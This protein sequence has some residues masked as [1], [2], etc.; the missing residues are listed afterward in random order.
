[1]SYVAKYGFIAILASQ[2][3]AFCGLVEAADKAASGASQKRPNVLFLFADDQRP[4][5]IAALGNPVIKTPN[6]DR[7]VER[8]MTFTNAYCMGST[9]PAVC[10]PSRHMT[11]SGMSL[12][13]YDPKKMEGTFGDVMRKAGY[14][15]YHQSKSGNTA[16]N[17]HKA[18]E[19]SSYLKDGQVRT[20]G[21][22]GRQAADDAISFLEGKWDRQQP[23][24]MYI[25]FAGPHDPRVAAPEWMDLYEREKIPLPANYAPFHSIDNAELFIRDEKL[26][27]WPR[28][29]DEVR[30]HLHDYYGCISSID[31]NIGRILKALSDLGQ[32]DNTIVVFSADHGLAIGSHGLFGKQNLYE[33]SMGT[34]LVFAGP[35]V[36]HGQTD[37]YAYLFDIF[38]TVCDLTGVEL[39][40]GLDGRSQGPV[41]RN[42]KN[43]VRDRVFLAYR[44]GQ[45]AVRVGDWKLIRYPQVNATQLFNLR[46]DPQELNNL[47]NSAKHAKRV[48]ELMKQLATAQQEFDDTL[49]LSSEKPGQAEVTLEY[50]RTR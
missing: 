32:L 47:A 45:R 37:A 2:A 19:Y 48:E 43:S 5:T 14:V 46:D 35:G 15:T 10:N 42:E 21:H 17:Y 39:P 22:H 29:K 41:I 50:F 7:L 31:F 4:D 26:A 20:S 38:P 12:F 13:R 34:P 25:G 27:P 30:R 6:L 40:A 28:T 44:Q 24:F 11:L 1:M 8:G 3:L 16:K 23:L 36:P 49:P 18:F 33:H 9:Q